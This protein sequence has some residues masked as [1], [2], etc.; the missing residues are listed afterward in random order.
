MERAYCKLRRPDWALQLCP[1]FIAS[2]GLGSG[3]LASLLEDYP[4]EGGGLFIV[5]PP[6]SIVPRKVRTLT[7]LM[8]SR[9]GSRTAAQLPGPA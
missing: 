6:A 4:L 1:D 3:R 9:L 8:V 2:D 7:N 5:R